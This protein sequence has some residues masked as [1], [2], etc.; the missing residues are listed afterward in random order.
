LFL[1]GCGNG[2][3]FFIRLIGEHTSRISFSF[4]RCPRLGGRH[5]RSHLD[6]L[7]RASVEAGAERGHLLIE[8]AVAAPSAAAFLAEF[9]RQDALTP[10]EVI[11]Q[12]L[13]FVE[14]L[15]LIGIEPMIFDDRDRRRASLTQFELR[16]TIFERGEAGQDRRQR[17]ALPGTGIFHSQRL[18]HVEALM[19]L[20]EVV[21]QLDQ[22][23]L[24]FKGVIGD[25]G[26]LDDGAHD[27][28]AL[29]ATMRRRRDE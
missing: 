24:D 10:G 15:L 28:S 1:S 9:L 13:K 26:E 16:Q 21:D 11:E 4:A 20:H 18:K 8:I 12:A 7:C 23:L 5:P 3:A 27:A 22:P 29:L 25:G 14:H 6:K 19:K 17:V 2:V